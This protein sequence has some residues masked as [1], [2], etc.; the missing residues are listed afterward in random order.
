MDSHTENY[1]CDICAT[2]ADLTLT[3]D[4]HPAGANLMVC[5]ACIEAGKKARYGPDGRISPRVKSLIEVARIWD[6]A[7][8]TDGNSYPRSQ[9]SYFRKI[10]FENRKKARELLARNQLTLP[11]RLAEETGRPVEE[12]QADDDEYPIPAID[13]LEEVS[14]DE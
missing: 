12:F 14:A 10:A 8:N 13:E 11:E 1:R 6:Q 7:V 2:P 3:S 4:S 9:Y 5:P